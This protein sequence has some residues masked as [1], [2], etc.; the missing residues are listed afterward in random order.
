MILL[1]TNIVSEMMKPTGDGN[2]RR[3]MDSYSEVD[4]FIATPVIAEL[5]FG[6]ALLP[7]G[8]KKEALTRACDTIEAEIFAG[9]ILT[10]DQRAAHAFARLRGKRQALGKP[11]NVMDALVASIA[12]AHAMT[13]A[14][15]NVAD[16]VD[17]DIAVVNPFEAR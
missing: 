5:R 4:F 6:L 8:R 12:S 1:D 11:L 2:V 14:T 3:W 10:F 9:Q 7:D 16:F 15:R 13:L 17:L